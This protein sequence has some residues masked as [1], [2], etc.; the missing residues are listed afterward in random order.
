MV[1]R[2]ARD[3]LARGLRSYLEEKV[4]AFDLDEVVQESEASQDEAVR[5]TA[6]ALWYHYDDVKD[7][8]VVA[9]KP[10]WDYFH[11]LLLLL[12]SDGELEVRRTRTWTPRQFIAIAFVV[13][14]AAAVLFFG[15]EQVGVGAALVCGVASIILSRW[16]VHSAYRQDCEGSTLIPFGTFGEIRRARRS[17]AWFKKRPYPSALAG[18]QI[19][20]PIV[21]AVL[22]LP[23]LLLWALFGPLVLL[24]QSLPEA[25][26]SFSV[27][28]P[29]A[30]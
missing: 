25:T 1:D 7:H 22:M 5:V 14:F 2:P 3:K 12:E 17:V 28:V 24:V 16:H 4:T 9:D 11:R 15:F 21:A 30:Q 27:R 10:E 29:T 13:G 20:S 8:H 19:R 6:G 26:T 23:W 18:R